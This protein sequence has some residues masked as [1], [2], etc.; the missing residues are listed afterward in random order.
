MEDAK[1]SQSGAHRKLSAFVY[2]VSGVLGKASALALIPLY[3]RRL[4]IDEYGD[5][6]IAQT[7]ISLLPIVLSCGFISAVVRFYFE[8]HTSAANGFRFASAARWLVIVTVV[9]A[10]VVHSFVV[11]FKIRNVW[12][13]S[14]YQFTLILWAAA[15]SAI[16]GVPYVVCRARQ[17]PWQAAG[18]QSAQFAASIAAGL[19][20]VGYQTRGYDGALIAAFVSSSAVGLAASAYIFAV[21]PAAPLKFKILTDAARFSV[22]F[23]PHY[24]FNQLQNVSD[25]W[26]MRIAGMGQLLA[27]YA[28]AVQLTVPA[29]MVI[30]AWNDAESP[31]QGEAY[32][33]GG[34]TALRQGFRRVVRMYL[35][36]ALI[37]V[38]L[39][40]V[41]VLLAGHTI[42]ASYGPSTKIALLLLGLVVVEAIYYPAASVCFY[43]GKPLQIPSITVGAG[44]VTLTLNLLLIPR[45]GLTGALVARAAAIA[46]RSGSMVFVALAYVLQWREKTSTRP[47]GRL[48]VS[49]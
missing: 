7:L 40:A 49:E 5:W 42:P 32:R 31:R 6:A 12:I 2:L 9:N 28:V 30:S 33:T 48:S 36:V 37:A 47:A 22:P 34:I 24:A 11:Y 4:T 14:G 17:K 8:P 45:F 16:A 41:F 26:S 20:F 44:V 1:R 10:A 19:F 18:W 23:I 35:I 3:T 25:R 46:L 39:T 38:S 21:L 43:A 27:A 29:N 13:F 15:G